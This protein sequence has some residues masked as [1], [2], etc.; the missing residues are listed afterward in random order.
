MPGSRAGEVRRHL[1][2]FRRT[3]ET[4]ARDRT[5]IRFVLPTIAHVEGVVSEAVSA[6]TVPVTLIAGSE[7]DKFAALCASDV[8][9]AASGTVTLELSVAGLPSVVVYRANPLTAAII[10]RIVRVPYVSMANIIAGREVMPEFLQESCT[11]E[12]LVDAIGRLLDDEAL[13]DDQKSTMT[14]VVAALGKG[15][16]PP[17]LRAAK[18]VLEMVSDRQA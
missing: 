11:S 14:D 10:R 8:A 12:N 2:V 3:V 9:L 18:A 16:E 7:D 1:P 5:S 17:H 4:L 13:R 15:G 6:W